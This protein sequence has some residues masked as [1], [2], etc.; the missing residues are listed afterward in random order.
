M[1]SEEAVALRE[2]VFHDK[3]AKSTSLNAIRVREAFESDT[4]PENRFILKCMGDL[5]GKRVLD[6]GC[7]LGE[8][9]V[10]FA[11]QGA[12]VTAVDVSPAMV[13]LTM[14]L[15]ESCNV[16]VRGVAASTDLLA[17]EHG[18]FDFVYLANVAHHVPDRRQ[19]WMDVYHALK[20]GGRFYSWDPL[21]YNPAINIYRRIATEVRTE[22]EEPFTKA[23]LRLVHGIFGNI[24]YR[25]FW[26][27]TLSIFFKYYIMDGLDPNKV[28]FWKRIFEEPKES[29]G[30]FRVLQRIDNF[31]L[32]LPIVKWQ[33]WNIVLSGE[34]KRDTLVPFGP[35]PG[36]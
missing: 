30:W 14:K 2:Q 9:S 26:L 6:L 19:L 32:S 11:M 35:K 8:S 36:R 29:L 5:K 16:S 33:A 28:R 12:D 34:K 10:Y 31:L 7:G 18:S 21:A 24:E 20:V 17:V 4:A 13:E 23:D 15:A 27:T 1:S 25:M 22:D 3:W